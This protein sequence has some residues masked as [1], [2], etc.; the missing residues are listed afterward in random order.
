MIRSM[1]AAVSGMRNHQ[2]FLDVIGN[3]IANINTVG[4]KA[5]RILF[6]DIMSQLSRSASS[7]QEGRGGTNPMQ[8]GLGMQVGDVSSLQTQGTFQSTGKTTDLA[9]QGD[10]F[11]ILNDGSRNLYTRDGGFDLAIDGTLVNPATGMK[12][13]GW[14]VGAN[15]T[16]DTAQPTNA[17]T[18][19][20]GE[21]MAGTPSTAV[22]ARGNLDA[23]LTGAGQINQSNKSGGSATIGGVYTGTTSTSY[24]VRIDTVDATGAVTAASYRASGGTWTSMT[25]SG[26]TFTIGSTGLNVALA[27]SPNNAANDTYSFTVSPPIA[28]TSVGVYDSLGS[29]HTIKITF[30][31]TGQNAWSWLASSSEAGVT[32]TPTTATGFTFSSAGTYTGSQPAGTIAITLSNGATVP[33]G[34]T[35]DLSNLSQLAGS[36]E[37]QTSADGAPA[38]SLVS[39]SIGQAGDVVGVYTNGR[40]KLVGQLALARFANPGGL[41]RSGDN[42]FETS[43]NSGDPSVGVPGAGGRGE[44]SS[45]FLEMSN[46]D[47]ALQ[48]TNMIMAQRGFQANS[49]VITASDEVLQDLVNLKR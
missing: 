7:P 12:V 25:L 29:L 6:S 21:T 4:F 19:P 26:G 9:I 28:E 39:F 8:V 46:V 16:V 5:S 47:L 49:R 15:G 45:G 30:T 23:R 48:F 22:T 34:V 36:S 41:L 20:F 31:K 33:S 2:T 17:I 27:A 24:D 11:F 40:S 14:L 1:L 13:Q 37:V 3:N 43:A 38:G 10:G 35:L 32:L 18:I 44:V 42:L